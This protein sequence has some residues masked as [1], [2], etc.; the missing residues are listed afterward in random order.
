MG[1]VILLAAMV[2]S[3]VATGVLAE[4]VKTWDIVPTNRNANE[5]YHVTLNYL[6]SRPESYANVDTTLRATFPR[7]INAST[8]L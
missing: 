5:N 6:N 8:N 2:L 3:T 7:W 4:E 1:G